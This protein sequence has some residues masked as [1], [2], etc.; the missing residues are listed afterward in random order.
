MSMTSSLIPDDWQSFPDEFRVRI[1]TRVG[2]QRLMQTHG[3]LLLLLHRVPA[4]HEE[5]REGHL[6]W[7]TTD[8]TWKANVFAQDPSPVFEHLATYKRKLE[9]FERLEECA[10][11][12]SDYFAVLEGLSP[13]YRATQHLYEVLQEARQ[14]DPEDRDLILLRDHAYALERSAE[15]LHTETKVALDFMVA[16]QTEALAQASHHMSVAAHR[17]NVLAAF[18]FPISILTAL[19]G[20]SY[21]E[22][23]AGDIPLWG[24][25]ATVALGFVFGVIITSLITR[26]AR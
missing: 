7:K 21:K 4:A 12:S 13:F 19:I 20:V 5:Q 18:F 9:E 15:L 1:G 22:V 10:E 2:R 3:Q 25:V 24:F 16:K 17:L 6:F 8:G 11:E 23:L 14:S 26:P